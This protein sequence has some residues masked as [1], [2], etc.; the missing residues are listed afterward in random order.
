MQVYVSAPAGGLEKPACELKA[1]AKTRELSP[2]ESEELTMVI[3]GYL[4]SS[5]N[6]S[7][8]RWETAPGTYR[9]LIGASVEDIRCV[10]G[11]KI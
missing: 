11:F 10:S 3:D 5:F 6:E 4:L 2:G 8:G 9:V 7:T 1:F